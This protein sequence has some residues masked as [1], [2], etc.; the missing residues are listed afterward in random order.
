MH[1]KDRHKTSN[2]VIFYKHNTEIQVEFKI[3]WM[4][5]KVHYCQPSLVLWRQL[6]D[7]AEA[8]VMV[9]YEHREQYKNKVIFSFKKYINISR[10]LKLIKMKHV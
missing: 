3:E 2:A 1:H 7:S 4:Q 8:A 5:E 10:K 9:V 6:Y